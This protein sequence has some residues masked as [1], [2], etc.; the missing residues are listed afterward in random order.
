M[1]KRILGAL[2]VCLLGIGTVASAAI[3]PAR[4]HRVTGIGWL[5]GC[6][7]QTAARG[8]IEEQWMR[9]AGGT[10]LGVG[11]TVR[12]GAERDSTTEFEFLRVFER[13]G[14]LVYAALP[15]GQSYTEF[16]E[17][18]LTDSSVSFGNPTHDFPQFVRYRRHGADSV[19]AGIDGTIQGRARAVE[20][21]YARTSCGA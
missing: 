11:R 4:A 12:L 19:I 13:A 9:P 15:S 16:T 5:A 14:K 7:R 1:Q 3:R 10:M 6:W 8:T 17:T 18:E 2:A 21:K 20:F